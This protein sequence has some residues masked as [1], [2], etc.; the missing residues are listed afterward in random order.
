M[1]ENREAQAFWGKMNVSCAGR[2]V[3][4]KSKCD[5]LVDEY[6]HNKG[7]WKRTVADL[8]SFLLGS[9]IILVY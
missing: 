2:L 6:F 8:I 3:K 9:I 5:F 4:L 1:I 7:F